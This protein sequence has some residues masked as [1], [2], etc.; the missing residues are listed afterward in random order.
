MAQ[1]SVDFA[2]SKPGRRNLAIL[3]REKKSLGRPKKVSLNVES[4][5]GGL[6]VV[7]SRELSRKK[8]QAQENI[9]KWV[10]PQ[11]CLIF[12]LF[13]DD[14]WIILRDVGIFLLYFWNGFGIMLV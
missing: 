8:R 12:E 2:N 6:D 14:V 9:G 11:N 13:V 4:C 7:N 5:S 10:V 3:L 1:T